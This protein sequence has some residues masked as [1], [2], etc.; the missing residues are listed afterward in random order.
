MSA[1]VAARLRGSPERRRFTVGLVTDFP[2]I[3]PAQGGIDV[4]SRSL[5]T[6]LA[7][8]ESRC[9]FVVF[10]DGAHRGQLPELDERFTAVPIPVAAGSA[11]RSIG[12]HLLV[13]PALALRHGVELLHFLGGNRRLG[14]YPGGHV[15]ATVHDLHQH[16]SLTLYGPMRYLY[17][18]TVVVPLLRRARV[19]AVSGA[20]AADI[21]RLLMIPSER[22]ATIPN[23]VDRA[24]LRM[25]RGDATGREARARFGLGGDF[26]LYVS[27]LEHPRKNHV[28]L[29]R[30]FSRLRGTPGCPATLVLAGPHS[31]GWE[32]V[33]AEIAR[34][35]AGE[36]IR[37]LGA[38]PDEDIAALYGCAR[39]VVHPSTHEGFGLPLLEAMACGT[40]VACSDIPAFRELA[41]AAA[42]FFDPRD[43]AA[44]AA[45]VVELCRDESRRE[46]CRLEGLARSVPFTWETTAAR[47]VELYERVLAGTP[48]P[49]GRAG[50]PR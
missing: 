10:V 16:D 38:V 46:R 34:V 6:A 31:R 43:P 21:E 7:R 39:A 25:S 18:R 23:G 17:Y 24:R 29:I 37:V 4:Y 49:S 42:V 47:V 26:L 50:T 32:A 22:I 19:I 41:G 5:V 36:A 14:P 1:S 35:G 28:N 45:A 33:R 2:L 12:W 9:R 48:A 8:V 11:V 15:M 27:A 13:L 20:T 3:P 30:A 44:I 40:P